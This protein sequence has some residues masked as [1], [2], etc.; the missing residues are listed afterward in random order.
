MPIAG[1]GSA[2]CAR[3]AARGPAG[4]PRSPPSRRARP[5]PQPSPATVA[6]ANRRETPRRSRSSPRAA[7][8]TVVATRPMPRTIAT[9]R[10]AP[11]AARPAASRADPP[12]ATE[13]EPGQAADHGSGGQGHASETGEGPRRH[14]QGGQDED[15]DDRPDDRRQ[16]EGEHERRPAQDDHRERIQGVDRTGEPSVV[17]QGAGP[18]GRGRIGGRASEHWAP[19]STATTLSTGRPND[20][21]DLAQATLDVAFFWGL[22]D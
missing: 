10:S 2:G 21:A 15:Q 5:G 6:V 18:P 22:V 9:T 19:G 13:I 17:D 8:T 20:A 4:R 1:G 14:G 16:A 11:S 3:A 7:G 12:L